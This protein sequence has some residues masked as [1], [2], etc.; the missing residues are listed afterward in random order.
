MG[1]KQADMHY[2]PNTLN[3]LMKN[4]YAIVAINYR[5]STTALFPVQIQ[6]CN[7]AMEFIYENAGKYKLDPAHV[8]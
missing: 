3:A 7:E 6:D 2:L 1:N 4:G 8:D 5:Y